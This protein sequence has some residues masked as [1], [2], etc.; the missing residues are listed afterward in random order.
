LLERGANP[1]ACDKDGSTALHYATRQGHAAVIIQLLKGGANSDAPEPSGRTALHI[2]AIEGNE[3]L[4]RELL[5]YGANPNA[6]SK[7]G[8][9]ALHYAAYK[10][11]P[12]VIML[13]LEW[14]VDVGAKQEC[15][16]TALHIAVM[17]RHR[18][19]ALALLDGVLDFQTQDDENTSKS[20]TQWEPQAIINA[21]DDEG[22]TPLH[23][24]ASYNEDVVRD[25]LNGGA[26]VQARSDWGMLP[27]HVAAKKGRR[28]IVLALWERTNRQ[29]RLARPSTSDSTRFKLLKE[30]ASIDPTDHIYQSLLG[31]EFWKEK[32]YSA[33]ISCYECSIQLDPSNTFAR[34]KEDI[35]HFMVYCEQCSN[36]IIGVRHKSVK[37]NNLDFC[38]ICSSATKQN[39]HSRNDKYKTIPGEHWHFPEIVAISS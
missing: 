38:S 27:I 22:F 25:L 39:P 33:A 34:R 19:T 17:K 28:D 23:Y 12:R 14:N 30:L 9:T 1:N 20:S 7:D 31:D 8:R 37:S 24:A 5:R 15:G 11:F 6:K 26:D 32:L 3:E 4:L 36:P 18:D 29:R 21:Q 2:A 16:K 13:L 10:G 35:N